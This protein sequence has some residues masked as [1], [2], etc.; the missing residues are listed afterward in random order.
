MEAE[1]AASGAQSQGKILLATVKGDVHD[2]GKNIVAVVLQCNNYEV[3]DAGVMQP[4]DDILNKAQETQADIIGLSGLIT[5]SLDEMVHVAKE[6]QRLEMK[7]PLIIGG[8]TTSKAHT[9]VKIE[10]EYDQPAV[11][12]ADASRAV[13]VAAK[14][15][16]PEQRDEFIAS[17]R[18]EYQVVRENRATR[19]AARKILPIEQARANGVAIDWAE[20]TPKAPANPGIT[21]LDDIAL[22]E[23]INFIDWTFFFHAWELKGRYPQ[24]LD[25]EKKGVEAAKLLADAKTM[26]ER[27][28]DQRWLQAKAVVGLFPANTV[29]D[30]IELYTDESRQKLHTTLHT[31]RQQIEQPSGQANH[32]L[33]D[34]IAPKVSGKPD[35]IGSFACTSGIGIE[36][37]L[38][39]FERQQDD[40]SAIM[41]KVLADRLAE[42]LAEWL[43]RKVRTELW[44]YAPDEALDNEELIAERYHGIRPAMGYPATPDHTEKDLLWELLS[45]EESTGIWLT[46]SK[47]MVPTAAVSGLYL[48]HPEAHYFNVGKIGRDQIADY[49]KRKGMELEMVEKWLGPNLAYES[50]S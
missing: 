4:A 45:V 9:A 22:S 24:I 48:A 36:T 44:G 5:P 23:L 38:A 47:A 15:L 3:I 43:H 33:S 30:D 37:K 19:D 21:V 7:Q 28:V 39:E 13:G 49:A 20:F 17:L 10:P 14:L 6:M 35:Y 8:A 50:K 40:Y 12:V 31:L 11:Y 46:E 32:A 41:L 34:F 1:K 29:G 42:A 16:S 25:D 27:I 18:S 26:L 2:I